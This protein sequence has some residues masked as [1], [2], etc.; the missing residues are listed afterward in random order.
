MANRRLISGPAYSG[1]ESGP[2]AEDQAQEAAEAAAYKIKPGQEAAN[3]Y[4]KHH[5]T[6]GMKEAVE[7]GMPPEIFLGAPIIEHKPLTEKDLREM[8]APDYG[9]GTVSP[10]I[11]KNYGINDDTEVAAWALA[12]D[13]NNKGRMFEEEWL[14]NNPRGRKVFYCGPDPEKRG[15]PH[16]RNGMVLMALP[17]VDHDMIQQRWASHNPAQVDQGLE[18][19]PATED[20][21]DEHSPKMAEIRK[22]TQKA[23]AAMLE[24]SPSAHLGPNNLDRAMDMFTAEE[25]EAHRDAARWHNGRT[26]GTD[27]VQNDRDRAADNLTA[28]VTG[29]KTFAMGASFDANGKVVR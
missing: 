3:D 19:L 26:K 12:D 6:D 22:R 18:G 2:T 8:F 10:T 15:K 21:V 25:V 5:T 27:Q 13:Y 1:A 24:G 28:A 14:E 11:R 4:L 9:L 20:E 7:D 17:R 16:T 29:K 23:I